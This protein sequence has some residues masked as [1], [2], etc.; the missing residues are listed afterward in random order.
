MSRRPQIRNL[1]QRIKNPKLLGTL[2]KATQVEGQ[3]PEQEADAISA[4]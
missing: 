1:T 3:R 2:H 4:F